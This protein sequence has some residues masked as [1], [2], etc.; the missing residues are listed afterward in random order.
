MIVLS[1]TQRVVGI[2][3]DGVSDV[4]SLNAEAI[5]PA[6]DF[7]VTLST[8]YLLGLGSVD[9]RMIIPV[10]IEKLL[11]SEEME[12]VEKSVSETL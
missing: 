5:K 11:T 1:L 8:D 12:L 6:P 9:E 10:D 4:L 7:S 2:V 3:V